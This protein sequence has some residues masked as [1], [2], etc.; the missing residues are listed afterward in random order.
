M[1]DKLVLIPPPGYA[2][3]L[4]GVSQGLN[5]VM[6]L[7]LD[8]SEPLTGAVL[9]AVGLLLAVEASARFLH[10]RTTPLPTGQPSSLVL[11]GPY[12]WSRNPMYLGLL[13]ALIGIAF[14]LGS[15]WF[16]LAPAA[17]FF[18]VDRLFVRFEEERLQGLFG[19]GY[20]EL[21]GRVRR[22]L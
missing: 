10:K 16:F 14:L 21:L 5:S 12:L 20:A 7:G 9:I 3:A 18:V 1:K 17:F 15:P 6:P 11:E 13:V 4:L 2:L 22:W 19:P 8:L